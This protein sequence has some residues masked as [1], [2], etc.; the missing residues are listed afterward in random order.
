MNQIDPRIVIPVHYADKAVKY[1]VAQDDLSS[2]E[3]MSAQEH[4]VVDK[5]KIK[6][7]IVPAARTVYEL[8][9]S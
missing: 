3:E 6:N 8:N 1:D 7:G 2:F 4:E 5:L 9:R